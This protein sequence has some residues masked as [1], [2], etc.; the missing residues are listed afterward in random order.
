MRD[1]RFSLPNVNI[2]LDDESVGC[3]KVQAYYSCKLEKREDYQSFVL[4]KNLLIY[5]H[6]VV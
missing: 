6:M 5:V 3:Y 2:K 1:F 4:N